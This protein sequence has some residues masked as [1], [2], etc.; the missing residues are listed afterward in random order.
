M[1]DTCIKA[2]PDTHL[3]WFGVYII[4]TGDMNLVIWIEQ[5]VKKTYILW[6]N[7]ISLSYLMLQSSTKLYGNQI[8]IILVTNKRKNL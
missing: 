7:Q 6:Q 4:F 5:V 3:D 2:T 8:Y 1:Q